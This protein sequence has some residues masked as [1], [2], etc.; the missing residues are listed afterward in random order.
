ML[1]DHISFWRD[2]NAS[3]EIIDWIEN[4]VKLKF[5][6]PPP[7]FEYRNHQ[8]NP[9]ESAFI[10]KEIS[11]L[12][13]KGAISQVDQAPHCVSP[14]GC[15]PKK[16]NKFRL[17]ID[18]RAINKHVK[19]PYYKNEGIET[20]CDYIEVGDNLITLDLKDGF[21]HI[22]V[23]E[24]YRTYL[25]FKWRN[26]YFVWNV[27]PFGLNASPW[28]FNKVIRAFVTF[29]RNSGIRFCMFVDDGILLAQP[30]LI[31]EHSMFL[32]DTCDKLGLRINFEKSSL[33]FSTSK[34]YIGY[35]V[36]SDNSCGKPYIAIPADRISKLKKDILRVIDKQTIN[37]R[38]LA[39]ICGQCISFAK[40]IL[41]AKLLLRNLYA[42]LARRKNWSDS[43]LLTDA[44]KQDLSWWLHAV[45]NWN[46]RKIEKDTIQCQVFTDASNTGWGATVNGKEA[47][48]LWSRSESY[49]HI[50]EKELLTV[51]LAIQSFS[52]FL[53]SKTVQIVSDNIATVANIAHLGGPS[54]PLSD[55]TRKIWKECH[56]LDIKLKATH[57]AGNLNYHADKLS[58]LSA[59]NTYSWKLHPALF[60]M[61]D[62]IWGPHDID[63]FADY[64]TRQLPRYNSLYL[65]PYT[66]GID[67]LAQ[68][69]WNQFNNYVNPPFFLIPR[70]LDTIINQKAEATIIAP[71]WPS[72]PWFNTLVSLSV[73]WPLKLPNSSM[74]ILGKNP[75]PRKNTH[76]KLYAWRVSGLKA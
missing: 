25:G 58:R 44:A 60:R 11:D 27:L 19:C 4:G 67:A 47:H 38:F 65:D 52:D 48:G 21:H 24:Q 63:R 70:I 10:D 73:R 6:S 68:T 55:I 43:L 31:S 53:K 36:S 64:Q 9:K 5:A 1:K 33:E 72:Q 29:V 7:Q 23:N 32:L 41:P 46:G 56:N 14:I 39:R 3:S 76:W 62:E 35:I 17:I 34:K 74:W 42:V 28:F 45:S 40:A 71:K 16:G 57:L 26:R 66:S 54:Q 8:L 20:V 37:A 69:D 51:L 2:I 59:Y 50:N 18:L 12:L 13:L 61:I 49:L 75:E 22:S 30:E 15:V